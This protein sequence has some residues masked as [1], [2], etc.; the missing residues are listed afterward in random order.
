MD[1][2]DN[3]H[4]TLPLAVG[5]V[6]G[7]YA[8][9]RGRARRS[10][11]WWWQ[12]FALLVALA[13]AV[14]EVLLGLVEDGRGPVS[15]VLAVVLLLPNVSVCVRRLHDVSRSGW[16]LLL[17]PVPLVGFAVLL[18]F[19]LQPSTPGW[20]A[21]GP[22]PRRPPVEQESSQGS[23]APSPVTAP[24]VAPSGW[25]PPGWDLPDAVEPGAGRPAQD[26]GG[27][28]D[29]PHHGRPQG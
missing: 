5:S 12:L 16:W 19:L 25:T 8:G 4:V 22:D 23:G 26:Q 28:E 27:V 24:Q 20:N 6:L 29:D 9:F 17:A 10:E 2:Q 3:E 18:V 1:V 14:P 15:T 21:H 11:F 7:Q 13:V